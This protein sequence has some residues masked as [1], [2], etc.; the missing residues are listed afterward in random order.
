VE[1][2]E[3]AMVDAVLEAVTSNPSCSFNT[4]I[5]NSSRDPRKIL[6]EFF[7]LTTKSVLFVCLCEFKEWKKDLGASNQLTFSSQSV[8]SSVVVFRVFP[9]AICFF[10]PKSV[11]LRFD[12][13]RS[14]VVSL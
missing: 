1:S 2:V 8:P 5:I 12:F 14:F 13:T 9:F 3:E 4:K 11:Q 6:T 7:I 10:N